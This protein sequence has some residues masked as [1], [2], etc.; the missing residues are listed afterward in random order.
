[1]VNVIKPAILAVE[2]ISSVAESMRCACYRAS[3]VAA[4]SAVALY[5]PLIVY[6][7]IDFNHI[8]YEAIY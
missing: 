5:I 8:D 1:M 2:Q 4:T 3:M 6:R 7:L